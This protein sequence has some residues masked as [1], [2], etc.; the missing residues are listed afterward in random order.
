MCP[1]VSMETLYC[2]SHVAAAFIGPTAEV[3]DTYKP[4]PFKVASHA[5]SVVKLVGDKSRVYTPVYT[6][7]P[8]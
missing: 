8:C 4:L 7:C 5:A 1:M 3:T 2:Q 6:V